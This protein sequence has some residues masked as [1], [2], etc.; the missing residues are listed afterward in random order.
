MNIK[1]ELTKHD[2][3][4]SYPN[5]FLKAKLRNELAHQLAEWIAQGNHI[6]IV[7]N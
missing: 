6:S 4:M 2:Y 7:E 3:S 1:T 5:I